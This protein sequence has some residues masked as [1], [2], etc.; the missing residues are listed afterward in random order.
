MVMHSGV[1]S[2]TVA[3]AFEVPA[4]VSHSSSAYPLLWILCREKPY[5]RRMSRFYLHCP[6][7]V[8]SAV[9]QVSLLN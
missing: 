6:F 5:W 8:D 4:T 3:M 9:A 7:Y 2:V 1:G